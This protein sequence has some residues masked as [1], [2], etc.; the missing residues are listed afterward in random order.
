[1]ASLATHV[2]DWLVTHHLEHTRAQLL[3]SVAISGALA[4]G[5]LAIAAWLAGY[6]KMPDLFTGAAWVW[7]PIA[8]AGELVT[9][10]GYTLAYHNLA[11]LEPGRE[12][13]LPRLLALVANGF[14]A[15]IPRGGFA[16]DYRVL[17]ETGMEEHE[18]RRS[19]LA[20][21]AL[22]Y[23]ILAPAACISAIYLLL[24]SKVAHPAFTYPWAIAVP[25]GF[26]IGFALLAKRKGWHRRSGWRKKLADG[27]DLLYDLKRLAQRPL[28]LGIAAYG[29]MIL[30]WAGDVFI[31]WACLRAFLGHAPTLPVLIVGYAT[32]YALTRRTLPL[33]GAGVVELFLPFAL[34]WLGVPLAP[35]VLA[36]LAYRIFNLWLPLIPAV[37]G[38]RSIRR[39]FDSD[40]SRPAFSHAGAGNE[41]RVTRGREWVSRS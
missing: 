34:H 11:K 26:G 17:V 24:V 30:Y 12:L 7:F 1:M 35:A 28:K 32:G 39:T 14:G 15:F 10:T 41:A 16:A 31:L 29:G 27:L 8:L 38:Y 23:V 20:I 36:V 6:G 2:K 25:V 19:V 40:S 13:G 21:A 33:A 9:Y 5:G 4:V 37:A 18:A 3:W 22:E